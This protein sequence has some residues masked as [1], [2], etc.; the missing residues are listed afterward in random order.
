MNENIALYVMQSSII[1]GGLIFTV[2]TFL[3][4]LIPR[5]FEFRAELCLQKSTEFANK[6]KNDHKN[7]TKKEI[8]EFKNSTKLPW[9][10]S[11]GI[12][13]TFILYLITALLSTLFL[14]DQ[15]KGNENLPL[16][17]FFIATLLFLI[18]GFDI[19]KTIK[20]ILE[21]GLKKSI[22]E[23]ETNSSKGFF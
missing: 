17:S 20:E 21:E 19:L 18:T 12:I 7:L 11:W 6:A 15:L 1:A 8:T 14:L 22:K 16:I 13:S 9:W 5:I 2:F 10:F 3:N 23:K 4:Q